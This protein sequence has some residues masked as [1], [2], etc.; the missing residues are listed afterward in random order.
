MMQALPIMLQKIEGRRS[1]GWQDEMV[2]WFNEL[3][4][5]EFEQTL[6]D[7]EGKGNLACCSP[8]GRKELDTIEQLNIN[9]KFLVIWNFGE[10][11]GKIAFIFL[12]SGEMTGCVFLFWGRVY[13]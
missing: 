12:K 1:S 3:N 7:G 11:N 9:N 2:N 4:G 8:R 5:H 6:G 13:M 10:K